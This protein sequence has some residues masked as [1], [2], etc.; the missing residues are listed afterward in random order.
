MPE[1]MERLR[2]IIRD[3]RRRT[4]DE[5]SMLVGISHGTCLKILIDDLK[6]QRVTSVFVPRLLSVDQK[7]RQLD[8]CLDFKENAANEPS[9]L[10]NVITGDETWV[11]AY[12]PET[13]TESSQWKSPG[14]SRPKKA[15]QV[16][17]NIKSML[18]SL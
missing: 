2:Q 16:R 14:S 9:F 4:I 6:M 11:Y 18:I 8:V 12:D 13:K 15:G 3:D 5:V 17:S 7:Q 10:S 1:M